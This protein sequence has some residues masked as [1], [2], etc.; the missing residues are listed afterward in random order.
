MTRSYSVVYST[1]AKTKTHTNRNYKFG[2]PGNYRIA[3]YIKDCEMIEGVSLISQEGDT[4]RFD[5]GRV[6]ILQQGTVKV[7]PGFHAPR[8]LPSL[9]KR[10]AL[11]D[12]AIAKIK[13]ELSARSVM[14]V[15]SPLTCNRGLL[16]LTN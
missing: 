11:L 12:Q 2:V 15:N 4:Y 6:E 3:D 5:N 1:N 10:I 14:Q 13:A 8:I 9:E 7:G 16:G